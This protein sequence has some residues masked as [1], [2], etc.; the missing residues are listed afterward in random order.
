MGLI[1][2][3]RSCKTDGH[4]INFFRAVQYGKNLVKNITPETIEA[5]EPDTA[6]NVK[7]INILFDMM[8]DV[9]EK[10]FDGIINN[11]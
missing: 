11:I 6:D 10:A 8:K 9:Q 2:K 1:V 7:R 5:M 4:T 3:N